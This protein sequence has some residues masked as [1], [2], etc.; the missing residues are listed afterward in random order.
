MLI[1][2]SVGNFRSFQE[3]VSLTLT[4]TRLKSKYNR[5][6]E[7]NVAHVADDLSL[8]K[9]SVIY[10]ANASGKSNLFSAFAFMKKF[11]INSARESQS[12]DSIA[13]EPFRLDL[14]SHNA[15][16]YFE[17]LFQM[18]DR[19]YRYGFEADRRRV[20]SE[21]LFQTRKQEA[22][23]FIREF[24]K[25]I[26]MT[27]KFRRQEGQ[28]WEKNT[29]ENVL[30]LSVLAQWNGQLS[31]QILDWFHNTHAISGTQE[32]GYRGFTLNLF[33]DGNK[34]S[35]K[36]V[37]FIR[38]A[39]FGIID[40]VHRDIQLTRERLEG[41]PNEVAALLLENA[42]G[43]DVQTVH[44]RYDDDENVIGKI[45]FSLSNDESEGTQRAFFLAGPLFDVLQNG[46]ILFVDELDASLHPFIVR[47]IVQLFNSNRTNP[48]NA[49][50]IFATHD[51][52]LLTNKLFRRD[53][54][55]FIEK[56]RVGASRLYSL[57]DFKPRQDASFETD[58][59]SGRYGAIP[60][61]GDI[62]RLFDKNG[63]V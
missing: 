36:I 2:F 13:V 18:N 30:F 56:S 59:L 32:A 33:R 50:L 39:D 5:L 8:L 16:S 20:H 1:Q 19:M 14:N 38:E 15:P 29:R 53:Q 42:V 7:N 46:Q 61:I 58:Y 57:A 27:E 45:E 26:D 23:V 51:T 47:T 24:G 34:M 48:H 9:S 3:P 44:E 37:E 10:G 22:K 52:N 49:Q 35:Q 6:N 60:F 4:T 63:A 41:V 62:D 17:V 43:S 54:I 12:T 11:V 31:K 55:W 25:P 40:I 28:N 21:W